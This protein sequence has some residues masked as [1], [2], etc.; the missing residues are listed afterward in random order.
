M[1]TS[2]NNDG[3][4]VSSNPTTAA[5][6]QQQSWWRRGLSATGSFLSGTAYYA[7]RP[8]AWVVNPIGDGLASGVVTGGQRELTTMLQ[9]NGPVAEQVKN[10]L[11]DAL[12]KRPPQE[13]FRLKEILDAVLIHSAPL[14][15]VLAKEAHQCIAILNEEALQKL[16]PDLSPQG[17][18]IIANM[19]LMFQ[20][21]VPDESVVSTLPSA[22]LDITTHRENLEKLSQVIHV[23][24]ERHQ[25]SLVQAM[26]FLQEAL[27]G[28]QSGL[29]G[30]AID[31]LKSKLLD[32]NQSSLTPVEKKLSQLFSESPDSLRG[33]LNESERRVV[34]DALALLRQKTTSSA[35]APQEG[36]KEE[37][38]VLLKTAIAIAKEKI[39]LRTNA[40]LATLHEQLNAPVGLLRTLRTG[41][42]T[43][44]Q[45]AVLR[46]QTLLER[47]LHP[48]DGDAAPWTQSECVLLTQTLQLFGQM[49][50]TA[51]EASIKE[52]IDLI[53][54]KLSGTEGPLSTLT[55]PLQEASRRLL[56]QAR[57]RLRGNWVSLGKTPQR[58]AHHQF[59]ETD[60]PILEAIQ[61]LQPQLQDKQ[62]S[63]LRDTQG[64]IQ[65]RLSADDASLAESKRLSAGERISLQEIEP[66]IAAELSG[67]EDL[68]GNRRQTILSQLNAAL[69]IVQNKNATPEQAL[70]AATL[71]QLSD[72]LKREMSALLKLYSGLQDPAV[73]VLL[74]LLKTAQEQLIAQ[75][76]PLAFL[77]ARIDSNA[78]DIV[79]QA[80]DLL[81]A[82][83]FEIG[84]PIDGFRRN[85]VDEGGIIDEAMRLLNTGLLDSERGVL[86]KATTY[87]K[88]ELTQAASDLSTQLLDEE[89]G[90]FAKAIDL[91]NRKLQ[92]EDGLL[93]T[94]D[95]KLNHE[96][97]GILARAA[98][99]LDK[100]LNEPGAFLDRFNARLNATAHPKISE[101]LIKAKELEDAS[102]KNASAS[103]Q[104]Q[105]AAKLLL[106]ITEIL[107]RYTTIFKDLDLRDHDLD[108]L[109]TLQAQLGRFASSPIPTSAEIQTILT[110]AI[111]VL[112]HHHHSQQ[113]IA[114]RT[115]EVLVDQLQKALVQPQGLIDQFNDRI[116][117]TAHHHLIKARKEL[118][119]LQKAYELNA[120]HADLHRLSQTLAA[121][122]GQINVDHAAVFAKSLLRFDDLDKVRDLQEQLRLFTEDSSPS[123]DVM[124]DHFQRMGEMLNHHCVTQAGI[125]AR[126]TDNL[127]TQ[128]SQTLLQPNGPLDQLSERLNGT[129]HSALTQCA[130]SMSLLKDAMAK[131]ATKPHLHALAANLVRNID[132]LERD[133]LA[134]FSRAPL[135]D[136]DLHALANLKQALAAFTQTAAPSIQ[137]LTPV[138]QPAVA[139]VD[140]HVKV[141]GGI[142]AGTAKA[143]ADQLTHSV[144]QDDGIVEQL[145][146][147]LTDPAHA[148]LSE[149]R[150]ALIKLQTAVTQR[151]PRA[152]LVR[153]AQNL[154]QAIQRLIL[155]QGD[156]FQDPPL[157]DG[158]IEALQGLLPHLAGFQG[159]TLPRK[160]EI[161]PV[162]KGVLAI[163]NYHFHA[164][165]GYADKFTDAVTKGLDPLLSRFEKLPRAMYD[166]FMG[167]DPEAGGP[168]DEAP[169]VDETEQVTIGSYLKKASEYL[170]QAIA[171][172]ASIA[173]QKA[174]TSVAGSLLY[175]LEGSLES[176]EG[177]ENFDRPREML[178]SLIAQVTRIQ[179]SGSITELQ[180]AI[181]GSLDLFNTF[182]IYI[183]GF[184]VPKIGT[185]GEP[186]E[187]PETPFLSNITQLRSALQR[188]PGI[189]TDEEV[190]WKVK[191]QEEKQKFVDNTTKYLAI[192]LI[193]EKFCGL[194]PVSDQLY[195]T[196]MRDA[197]RQEDPEAALKAAFFRQLENANVGWFKRGIAHAAYFIFS[198]VLSKFIQNLSSTYLEEAF[199]FIDENKGDDFTTLKNMLINNFTRYLTILGGAYERVAHNPQPGDRLSEMLKTEL[200]K[201]ECN[202]GKSN[203]ELYAGFA[204][205]VIKKCTGNR[206]VSWLFKV[207]VGNEEAIV[208]AIVNQS[209]GSLMDTNGYTHALNCVVVEQLQEVLSVM[210]EE[211]AHAQEDGTSV[212]QDAF[213]KHKKTELAGLVKNLFEI[214]QKS[215]CQTKDELKAVVEGNS[216][217]HNAVKLVDDLFIQDVIENVTNIMALTI[218]TLVKEDQL[219]KLTYKFTNLVNTVYE[220]GESYTIDEVNAKEKELTELTDRILNLSILTAVEEKFDFTGTKEQQETN[221]QI[222]DLKR[223]T[224]ALT[225]AA[226]RDLQALADSPDLNS[227]ESTT[228][229]K[230]AIQEALA[231]ETECSAASF[232]AKGGQ[233]NADNKEEL[234]ARYLA[235]A[236][237]SAPYVEHISRMRTAQKQIEEHAQLHPEL[238]GMLQ[239]SQEI[240]RRLCG[241]THTLADMSWARDQITILEHHLEQ[242]NRIR[243]QAALT[244]ELTESI[245]GLAFS[246]NELHRSL[247]IMEFAMEQ[248][249][250]TC[251]TAQIVQAKQQ[252]FGALILPAQ[253]RANIELLKTQ[254]RSLNDD[255]LSRRLFVQI[256]AIQNSNFQEQLDNAFAE[257]R[258]ISVESLRQSAAQ[259]N[260]QKNRIRTNTAKIAEQINGS[261]LLDETYVQT[262]MQTM[263]E[264]LVQARL[265][266]EL[267]KRSYQSADPRLVDV[268]TKALALKNAIKSNIE[269][270]EVNGMANQLDA[271]IHQLLEQRDTVFQRSTLT[272]EQFDIL[273]LTQLQLRH[274]QLVQFPPQ[275]A[276]HRAEEV[277]RIKEDALRNLAP[278]LE[279]LSF[280]TSEQSK[281]N[282]FKPVAYV[283]KALMDMNSFKN[284]ATELVFGRVKDRVD[285]LMTFIRREDT[286]KYGL[287][288][289]MFLI[290]YLQHLRG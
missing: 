12:I 184:R 140:H 73:P 91:L 160:E 55:S 23:M 170:G 119:E 199:K 270:A 121:T 241:N 3:L 104:S 87:L 70:R 88:T 207:F 157:R 19:Q 262:R 223:K 36:L 84:G 28:N 8:L 129:T 190:D 182:K 279:I 97:H 18:E 208:N 181:K 189:N 79:T 201:P 198:Y 27:V 194:T 110:E 46:V 145:G 212:R 185:L 75:D 214:L 236:K 186:V 25:G 127:A 274:L 89:E 33:M 221:R 188:S 193:Y 63:V 159:E 57:T 240:T 210:Q 115:G 253:I 227:V 44:D 165:A 225:E 133:R 152:E 107:T 195:F 164:Q 53:E 14:T 203:S 276:E 245:R 275:Q 267:M 54:S 108:K 141:Q 50:I 112:Q 155:S 126:T 118:A 47:K 257:F 260:E 86:T 180:T 239:I 49:H 289:H 173:S 64:L 96:E 249:T 251:L 105:I 7:S 20:A 42:S 171:E 111:E 144:M 135:R 149:A 192:K 211:Y 215:K 280:H 109:T 11:T 213:S 255:N 287:T 9:P 156:V 196:L 16:V 100:K 76:G 131:R 139:V 13:L 39:A 150:E 175:A 24:V 247:S 93:A 114:A 286:Y 102:L 268:E 98:V 117:A 137:E 288:N 151:T 228:K 233:L 132:T 66:L 224:E 166:A 204:E 254:I 138:L 74:P 219:H 69:K 61:F 162:L 218:G 52:A 77:E 272:G 40:A 206:F 38:K 32:T 161:L 258:R 68:S 29:I 56:S 278:A 82:K 202:L 158:D 172:G 147:R 120:S 80:I 252:A 282:V 62:T 37:E 148:H 230:T 183:N 281:H 130:Q 209:V 58:L 17:K 106:G 243:N 60:R 226:S 284:W 242:A 244:E 136:G 51:H 179:A 41:L 67:A 216:V 178:K 259:V 231:Y 1:A 187:N 113:G 21:L 26:A 34:G 167:R 6:P 48:T 103:Q 90:A 232:E 248:G 191:A 78:H 143:F 217:S 146:R 238:R 125:I 261:R 205:E 122:L 197:K 123:F 124:R 285:G 263:H 271:A 85:L 128:F 264:S 31:I 174:V 35:H 222:G 72:K 235:V 59:K 237:N 229:L 234:K 43:S 95:T 250:D 283:N 176:I 134:I 5:V 71:E 200:E 94:L 22:P 81:N 45:E 168:I 169:P 266:I 101:A 177:R 142:M 273:T 116:N 15:P 83:L 99:V 220:A 256:E 65:G 277:K 92:A 10:L 163:L 30:Q 153:H 246:L 265:N 269:A 154:T 2:T 4:F 290:P